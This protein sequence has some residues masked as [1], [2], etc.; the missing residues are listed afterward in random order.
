LEGNARLFSPLPFIFARPMSGQDAF[1]VAQRAGSLFEQA[2]ELEQAGKWA[3][4]YALLRKIQSE[5][6]DPWQPELL[7]ALDR[8]GRH[9]RRSGLR[10]AT[11]RKTLAG[12]TGRVFDFALHP[13]NQ[14]LVSCSDDGEL[15]FWDL[16]QGICLQTVKVSQD[17]LKQVV[18][19]AD[20]RQLLTAG[21]GGRIPSDHAIRTFRLAT[22]ASPALKQQITLTDSPFQEI[23]LIPRS[24]RAACLHDRSLT[25]IDPGSGQ[26]IQDIPLSPGYPILH[27][28]TRLLI[29]PDGQQAFTSGYDNVIRVWDL[30]NGR[31]VTKVK[32]VGDGAM[33]SQDGRKLISCFE[34]TIRIWDLPD[35]GL[36]NSL[37][38][39]EVYRFALTMTGDGSFLFTVG[40]EREARAWDIQRSDQARAWLAHATTINKLRLTPDDRFLVTA[41]SDM[42]LKVWELDWEYQFIG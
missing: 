14:T 15:R 12:H 4:A 17:W 38:L 6:Q 28:P 27:S 24:S 3:E 20:G 21:G 35:F 8:A 41:S 13:N 30:S 32:Q 31:L 10:E 23:A 19:S 40:Q 1:A 22:P 36:S 37:D 16:R 9:G 11:L 2:E 33:I 42:T 7:A 39:G 25:I 5:N 26:V 29:S 34:K 18:I